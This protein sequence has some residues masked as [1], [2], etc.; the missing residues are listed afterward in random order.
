MKSGKVLALVLCFILIFGLTFI[1]AEE[2]GNP[3]SGVNANKDKG[4]KIF[5]KNTEKPSKTGTGIFNRNQ[6]R[7]RKANYGACVSANTKVKNSCYKQQK[8]TRMGCERQVREQL[9]EERTG[10]SVNMTQL[11]EQTRE[12]SKTCRETYNTGIEQC[13]QA[14]NASRQSCESWRCESNKTFGNG[15]CIGI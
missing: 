4:F 2:A 12:R 9:R 8:E 5:G 10:D 15:T 3:D 7:V 1:V 11:R 6:E 13:K 14:F